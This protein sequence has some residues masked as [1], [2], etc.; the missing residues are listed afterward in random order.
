LTQTTIGGT[1]TALG[2][3]GDEDVTIRHPRYPSAAAGAVSSVSD[4]ARFLDLLTAG[5]ILDRNDTRA[6][7]TVGVQA[8]GEEYGLGLLVRQVSCG[9]AYGQV[10]ENTGYAI[11]A[12]TVPTRLGRAWWSSPPGR[13]GPTPNTSPTRPSAT[14]SAIGRPTTCGLRR[15]EHVTPARS[16][17]LLAQSGTR[18]APL[19][20]ARR[21]R[22]RAWVSG[23][24]AETLARLSERAADAVTRGCSLIG[25]PRSAAALLATSNQAPRPGG[26]VQT[27]L[28]D[29]RRSTTRMGSQH[30][31][32]PFAPRRVDRYGRVNLVWRLLPCMYVS[33]DSAM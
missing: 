30:G 7:E 1:P 13:P 16:Q 5:K 31:D 23:T 11:Q 20:S 8:E 4:V 17:S 2:Y 18:Q 14:N 22:S 12:W 27:A 24:G 15:N 19:R 29:T 28:P 9:T 3:S 33:S 10:G 32:W 6:M 26:H 21:P 25:T